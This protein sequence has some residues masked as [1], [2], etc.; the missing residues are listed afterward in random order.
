MSLMMS[1]YMTKVVEEDITKYYCW[2]KGCPFQ[3]SS[4]HSLL[5]LF[6]FEVLSFCSNLIFG[7]LSRFCLMPQWIDERVFFK[8][9]LLKRK[10]ILQ[11]TSSIVSREAQIVFVCI[12][13]DVDGAV[14]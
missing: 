4:L 5:R 1:F 9:F 8:K 2:R 10:E 13:K 11:N 6:V 3:T 14:L 12:V 7:D